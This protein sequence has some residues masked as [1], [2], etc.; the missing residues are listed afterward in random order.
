MIY[1]Q[2]LEVRIGF[3]QIRERIE[4][5]CLGDLGRTE[6]KAMTFLTSAEPMR[7]LLTL[8]LEAKSLLDRGEDIPIRPYE[9]PAPWIEVAGVDGAYLES[10]DLAVIGNALQMIR[11]VSDFLMKDPTVHPALSGLA[12]PKGFG[13][14]VVEV[15]RGKVNEEGKIKDT[16]S[17]ELGRI[18]RRLREEELRARRIAEQIMRQALDQGWCPEGSNPTIR[19]GRLVIPLTAEHK[20]RIK[21]YLVDQS[22]TGQT[23]FLEPAEVMEANNDLRDLVLEERKEIIRILRDL[24]SFLRS[25]LTEIQQ[26]YVFLGQM[27]YHRARA[28]FSQDLRASLPVVHGNPGLR[29]TNA[30]HPLLFFGLKNKRPLIPLTISLSEENHFLLVSGP[31]AGG[32]SVCLKTVGLIQYMA[33]CGLLVP[34]DE[35]SEVG[36]FDAMFLDIGDQQSIESD[37][38][39]YSS[40][41]KNMNFFIRHA[42]PRSLILMDELGAGTDPNFGGG[43]AQAVLEMLLMRKAWGL[44]TTHYYN[45]KAFASHY[46]GIVNASMQF[47]TEKLIPLFRLEIGQPGSSFALEIARKT[48]LSSDTLAAAGRIIGNELMGLESLMK[49]VAEEKVKLEDRDAALRER[50]KSVAATMRA[51]D[52]LSE[53]LEAQKKEI[54]NRAKSE[55]AAL[56]QETNREIEKTIRHIR[57]NKAEKQ[58]TRKVRSGLRELEKK[59]KP[60]KA[61][62]QA[63]PGPIHTGD[64]VRMMGG[65]V[66]G[67]VLSVKSKA[68]VIQFGDLRSTIPLDRLVKSD[69]QTVKP[70]SRS[71]SGFGLASQR[72]AFSSLLDVRG[73]R[74][75]EVLPVLMRFMDDAVQFGMGDVRIVH[76]KG[77]GVLRK[78][79]REY[80]RKIKTVVSMQ[81]EHADRGGDG[82]TLV[83]L[84]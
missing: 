68:A 57:E 7:V 54:L 69:Y 40:H 45:L 30:R 8:N 6:V 59:V 38:S 77:E 62:P 9:D 44:A 48:G 70:T 21:G 12:L 28:R 67:T 10:G 34:M 61:T 58:E 42:G 65:E 37:L 41:L 55:A 83:T 1:P 84:K 64:T 81:D 36:V 27:D 72:A 31:N 13:K 51:Y 47:D 76:G 73:M 11:E 32:K 25:H 20:R 39:T 3:D 24:T 14:A 56:L 79:V 4:R 53:K 26:G 23:V 80:V 19:D 33:Q 17:P 52:D 15:I 74:V 50:E 46:S 82:V 71:V 18:R 43:I 63:P 60:L 75:E 5:Y 2:D 22:A 49:Q 78:V 29:W 66:S 16:A 35:D